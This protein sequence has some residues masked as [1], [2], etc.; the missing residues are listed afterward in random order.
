MTNRSSRTWLGIV[1]CL[2][3]IVAMLWLMWLAL[4]DVPDVDALEGDTAVY[5]L[6]LPAVVVDAEPDVTW[7]EYA[8]LNRPYSVFSTAS[9]GTS[10][11]I[12][13]DCLEGWWVNEIADVPSGF[14]AVANAHAD[15]FISQAIEAGPTDLFAWP[16]ALCQ[17][18]TH[19][20]D[21]TLYE[22]YSV[23]AVYDGRVVG[24]GY[25][26]PSGS[27]VTGW[28]GTDWNIALY[29]A[30][31]GDVDYMRGFYQSALVWEYTT[32]PSHLPLAMQAY[33]DL[34]CGD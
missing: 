27:P 16:Y 17:A 25:D 13:L 12:T 22:D 11:E 15:A 9:N 30:G 5:T 24:M 18:T 6:F 10:V 28:S 19:P 32:N 4:N 34:G 21:V 8:T 1:F 2:G 31:W 33:A 20:D 26:C 23:T 3:L 7:A 29:D 14:E